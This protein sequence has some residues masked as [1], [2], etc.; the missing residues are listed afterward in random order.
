MDQLLSGQ[1]FQFGKSELVDVPSTY[2]REITQMV[3]IQK[4]FIGVVEP[5]S[6]LHLLKAVRHLVRIMFYHRLHLP[7]LRPL[8]IGTISQE[9]IQLDLSILVLEDVVPVALDG[10]EKLESA[11]C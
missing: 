10:G 9:D 3:S 1:F 7:N 4:N 5:F 8:R 11:L 6:P 2:L